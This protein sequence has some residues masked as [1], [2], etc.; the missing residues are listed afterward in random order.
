MSLGEGI[1]KISCQS[2]SVCVEESEETF[3]K[4]HIEKRK[5]VDGTLEEP[6]RYPI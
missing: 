3:E 1:Q 4:C 2:V 6:S 5:C